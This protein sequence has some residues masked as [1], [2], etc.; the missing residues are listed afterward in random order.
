[1]T[2]ALIRPEPDDTWLLITSAMHMPRSVGVFRKAGW[3]VLP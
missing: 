1:M 3:T 2:H